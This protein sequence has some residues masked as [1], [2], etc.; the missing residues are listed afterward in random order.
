MT[1]TIAELDALKNRV[2]AYVPAA[3]QVHC[4]CQ[5]TVADQLGRHRQFWEY[6][7][8]ARFNNGEKI[9]VGYG[10]E[11]DLAFISFKSFMQT[12]APEYLDQASELCARA[13][14]VQ[15]QTP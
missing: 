14:E 1:E 7:I 15:H 8:S 2:K 13:Q 10:I 11:A 12:E 5:I 3:E 6:T 4:D 9:V